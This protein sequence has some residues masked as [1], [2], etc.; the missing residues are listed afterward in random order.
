MKIIGDEM[1]AALAARPRDVRRGLPIPPVNLFPAPQGAG[2]LLVDF[3]TINTSTA[4]ALAAQRCCSL[5]GEPMGYWVAFLGSPQ[6]AETRWYLDPPGHPDCMSAALT[7]CPHIAIGR[8][9]RARREH[10][11]GGTIPPGAS[12]DKPAGYVLG[13]TR[14][15]RLRFLPDNGYSVFVAAP[16]RTVRRYAYGPDGRLSPQP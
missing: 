3:T 8:H 4:H 11:S 1:P 6:A 15:Y 10:G 9:R 14:A 7:L 2:E 16:F 5:C 12:G 13:I